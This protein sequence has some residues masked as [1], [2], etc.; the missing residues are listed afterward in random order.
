MS[1][2]VAFQSVVFY[3]I[4]CT[5]CAKVRHRQKARQQAKKERV[6][7]ARI[8]AEQPDLYRHP[9]PF[10]TNPYWG[11]EIQM[12]PS[13][14]KKGKGGN[15]ASKSQSQ[16]GLT[17]AGQ[18][19]GLG[20][21][22]SLAISNAGTS[23]TTNTTRTT[24]PRS[25]TA[26]SEPTA[27]ATS[28]E[29]PSSPTLT[30]TASISTADDW[31]FKRYQ[32]EDEELWGYG[33][34]RTGQQLM[35]AI[36]HAG[37]S[38]GRFVE[39][40]LGKDKQA[41]VTDEDR[42]N[43]YF[44][45]RNPPVN[46]YHPPVVSSKPAHRDGHRWMLQPPP[47]AKVMEGKVPVSRST[48]V[49]SMASSRRT[50]ATSDSPALG[51]LVGERLVEAKIRKGET[52]NE[53]LPRSTSTLSKPLTRRTTAGGSS[54][55]SRSQRTVR[56]RSHSLSTESEPEGST[57]G[58][59]QKRR[60]PRAR[61]PVIQ[62]PEID[63]DDDDDEWVSR[64]LESLSKAHVA[65]LQTHAAQRPRLSTIL[66][67]DRTGAKDTRTESSAGIGPVPLRDISNVKTTAASASGGHDKSRP[68][69]SSTNNGVALQQPQTGV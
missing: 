64:S 26:G 68:S 33:L 30:Q 7:K 51:R 6:E 40:K 21:R 45:P 2:S 38:A 17:S 44:T 19:S 42:H 60:R 9:S 50:A 37:T 46:D 43:F 65:P 34:S 22:S 1:I 12:G 27:V 39:A 58:V 36:K 52:P 29:E 62:N 69:D 67:S 35:D 54:A 57:E 14:P 32:R 59:V 16:R 10:S 5:P 63:D 47:S 48:S 8:E 23:T 15:D 66:S 25:Q 61:P 53:G 49:V 28:S 18:D 31:N 3:V 20:T 13:L 24:Q 4:A 56:S 11:E 41:A 55:R